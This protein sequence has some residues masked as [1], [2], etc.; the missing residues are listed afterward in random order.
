[1]PNY[2]IPTFLGKI[3]KNKELERIFRLCSSNTQVIMFISCSKWS[4]YYSIFYYEYDIT[5]FMNSRVFCIIT[6]MYCASLK[7]EIVVNFWMKN[8]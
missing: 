7:L 2:E 1:M 8:D 6:Y 5:E 3:Y 4:I